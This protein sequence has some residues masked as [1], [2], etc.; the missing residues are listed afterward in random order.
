MLPQQDMREKAGAQGHDY[1]HVSFREPRPQ[2]PSE[3]FSRLADLRVAQAFD[4]H[5]VFVSPGI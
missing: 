4:G 2:L 5:A 1:L 3:I